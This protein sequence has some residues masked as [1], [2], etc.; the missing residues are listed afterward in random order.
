M[1]GLAAIFWIKR[2]FFTGGVYSS[3]KA[4][5]ETAKCEFYLFIRS[6]EVDGYMYEKVFH[7]H[8]DRFHA[9]LSL[10]NWKY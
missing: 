5:F 4:T 10:H 3:Y 7:Y 1:A 8:S 2:A 6:G 9:C